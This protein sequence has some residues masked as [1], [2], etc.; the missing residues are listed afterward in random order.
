MFSVAVF[1]ATVFF[2]KQNIAWPE[3]FIINLHIFLEK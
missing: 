1:L 3:M 2:L